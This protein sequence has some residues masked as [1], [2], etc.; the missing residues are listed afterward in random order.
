LEREKAIGAPDAESYFVN[1]LPL[2]IQVLV[3]RK[4]NGENVDAEL[5]RLRDVQKRKLVKAIPAELLPRK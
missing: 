2:E 3:R 1:I 5:T 4:E